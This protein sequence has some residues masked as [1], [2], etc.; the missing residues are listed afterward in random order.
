[1]LWFP[2]SVL[3]AG[4]STAAP[5]GHPFGAHTYW[6][7]QLENGLQAISV[8]DDTVS[9]CSLFIVY[10]V[11]HRMEEDATHGIAHLLLNVTEEHSMYLVPILV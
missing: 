8:A 7:D 3:L 5:V 10:S 9:T 6:V 4:P 2:L 1:M 11:G